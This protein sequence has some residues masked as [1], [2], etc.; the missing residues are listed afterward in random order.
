MATLD[1]SR[2]IFSLPNPIYRA[3]LSSLSLSSVLATSSRHSLS[4]SPVL[5]HLH[6]HRTL[7]PC[8]S[9]QTN[10]QFSG[11]G[12]ESESE[13]VLEGED[14]T[15]DSDGGADYDDGDVFGNRTHSLDVDALEEEAKHA[16]QEYSRSLSRQL[17][18]GE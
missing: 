16:V 14:E 8:I 15:D 9:R 11:D 12:E 7:S 4:L 3:S 10:A 2:A 18:L 1:M 17:S 13:E 5:S 6:C